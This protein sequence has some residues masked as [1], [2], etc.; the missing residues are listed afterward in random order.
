MRWRWVGLGSLAILGGF[1]LFVR[2][3]LVLQAWPDHAAH[4]GFA[5]AG[6]VGGATMAR[7]ALIVPWREPVGAAFGA[8]AIV[9]GFWA[10][11]PREVD[12]FVGGAP[13][14]L[15][16]IAIVIGTAIGGAALARRYLGTRP[17]RVASALLD[18]QLLGGI[19]LVILALM[20]VM[21]ATKNAVIVPVLFGTALAGFLTQAVTP[22]RSVWACSGGSVVLVLIML[23]GSGQW[24]QMLAGFGILWLVGALGAAIAWRVLPTRDP[25]ADVPS[26]RLR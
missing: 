19:L 20:T 25:E 16:A 24:G 26:A 10:L 6:L 12:L 2:L 4:I 11:E 13:G 5:S 7:H 1:Y 17:T 8:I 3:M 18:V 9:V 21:H 23:T 14:A 15:L 22:V